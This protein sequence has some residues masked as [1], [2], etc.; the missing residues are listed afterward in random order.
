M[1]TIQHL[2]T[3]VSNGRFVRRNHC[4]AQYS[5]FRRNQTVQCDHAESMEFH[6]LHV[7]FHESVFDFGACAWHLF[8]YEAYG[9][10]A[11]EEIAKGEGALR[12]RSI[13]ESIE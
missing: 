7:H 13:Q 2:D 5:V 1:A 9:Q 8:H 11:F 10:N 12:E 3:A 4:A 6:V